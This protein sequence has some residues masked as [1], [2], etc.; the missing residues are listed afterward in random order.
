MSIARIDIAKK[1]RKLFNTCKF[2]ECDMGWDSILDNLCGSIQ[3]YVKSNPMVKDFDITQVK[4]KFGTLRFYTNYSDDYIDGMIHF[5]EFL[6]SK[7]CETC[8]VTSCVKLERI[9]GWVKTICSTCRRK[10]T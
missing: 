4:E 7:T 2:I 6:S 5:A 1:Y 8:G 10:I 3:E 9:G